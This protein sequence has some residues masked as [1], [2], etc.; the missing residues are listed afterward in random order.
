MFGIV[1]FE[2][3]NGNLRIALWRVTAKDANSI[4]DFL[5]SSC[6]SASIKL[7]DLDPECGLDVEA[8]ASPS[9]VNKIFSFLMGIGMYNEEDVTKKTI[10]GVDDE[11]YTF[12][13]CDDSGK[14]I[15]ET[16]EDEKIKPSITEPKPEQKPP[17]P[18]GKPSQ[19]T[20]DRTMQQ[21]ILEALKKSPMTIK[22]L[23]KEIY[24]EEKRSG[25]SQYQHVYDRLQFRLILDGKVT[26]ERTPEQFNIYVYK[27][28]Q[29]GEA[30]IPEKP[31]AARK[32][33]IRA[34][35]KKPVAEKGKSMEDVLGKPQDEPAGEASPVIRM[36]E[37]Q[38]GGEEPPEGDSMDF[39]KLCSV[40]H[41]HLNMESEEERIITYENLEEARICENTTDLW[42][43]LATN[44]SPLRIKI[45][46]RFKKVIRFIEMRQNDESYFI[47]DVT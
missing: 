31:K 35:A 23:T 14:P 20:T 7:F 47:L 46:E 9:D 5:V 29:S 15:T 30:A 16:P 13:R 18:L 43:Q 28:T 19:K 3:E 37:D 22:E 38:L 27:L 24:G 12:V 39:N 25:T 6:D 34:K 36:M 42:A 10:I 32:P 44:S 4:F 8:S 26:R 17:L 2:Y 11:N 33:R 41:R 40:I 45:N 1:R 21:K